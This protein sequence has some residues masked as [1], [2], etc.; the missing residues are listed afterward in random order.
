MAKPPSTPDTKPTEPGGKDAK[1][2]TDTDA[3]P[4]PQ[5]PTPEATSDPAKPPPAAKPAAEAAAAKPADAAPADKPE[6]A[7]AKP[8]PAPA[9]PVLA[10]ADKP[11]AAPPASA[12]ASD[13][14]PPRPPDASAT[15]E[16]AAVEL[17]PPD[18][19]GSGDPDDAAPPPGPAPSGD[20]RS[21]RRR[22][23]DGTE[24]F[25]LVYRHATFLI[26]RTGP[27][28]RRGTWQVVEY[29]TIAAAA[30]GYARACSGFNDDG[31]RDLA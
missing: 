4:S 1:P 18:A 20:A 30:T 5:P 7:P 27:V 6:P 3:G 16:A 13:A 2:A 14:P 22:Q 10:P 28:G 15:V 11:G 9:K 29:P 25:A 8:V 19:L 12:A 26:T 31:Y 24:Q 17:L 23:A 21:L